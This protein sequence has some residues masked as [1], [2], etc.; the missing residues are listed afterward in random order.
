MLFS[1]IT[2]DAPQGAMENAADTVSA[3]VAAGQQFAIDYAP[4]LLGAILVFV[5]GRIVVR[6][7]ANMLKKVMRKGDTDPMVA[8]FLANLLYG[9]GVTVVIIS[10]LGILGV[11]TTSA[12]AVL[13]AAGLAI[14]FALQ[15]SL[16]NFASGVMILIF[17][18]FKIGDFVEA[19]GT[20]GV[21]QDIAIFATVMK[22]GDNK[23]VILPNSSITE[24][25]I[26]NYSAHDTRRIDLIM[27]ISYDDDMGKAKALFA[28]VLAKDQAVLAEPAPTIGVVELAESSVNFVVRP[29]VKTGDY[30]PTYYRLTEEIKRRCDAEGISIPFPQR[31]VHLH[32]APAG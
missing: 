13:G 7:L 21:I 18:P 17:K 26:T 9:V 29:W 20:M 27:G 12:V 8:S 19:G 32:N 3:W 16:G 4:S 24:G 15:G 14:G 25:T 31:D 6:M 11:E 30:W 5:F 1:L 2:Q 28:D 10:A 23:K 22:T